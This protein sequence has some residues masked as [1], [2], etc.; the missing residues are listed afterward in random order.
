MRSLGVTGSRNLANYIVALAEEGEPV[1]QRRLLLIVKV[2]PLRHRVFGF[3][4]GFGK[5]TG[6]VLSGKDCVG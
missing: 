3:E 2:G 6:G 1:I 5:R 4:A